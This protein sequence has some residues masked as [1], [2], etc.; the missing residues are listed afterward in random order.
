M[1]R[2]IIIIRIFPVQGNKLSHVQPGLRREYN[3]KA[4]A[5]VLR[6]NAIDFAFPVFQ[7]L[8]RPFYSKSDTELGSNIVLQKIFFN[9]PSLIGVAK[10]FGI[11]KRVGGCEDE[12]VS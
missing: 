2:R 10:T 4:T 9:I 5:R 11:T 1:L 8:L 3:S 7:A 12:Y 6:R